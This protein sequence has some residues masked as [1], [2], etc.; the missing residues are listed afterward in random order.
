MLC[1][2][3][4]HQGAGTAINQINEKRGYPRLIFGTDVT[5]SQHIRRVS[6]NMGKS[7]TFS[8]PFVTHMFPQQLQ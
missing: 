8:H 2:G 4:E 6:K 7:Q 1:K 5:N 3:K